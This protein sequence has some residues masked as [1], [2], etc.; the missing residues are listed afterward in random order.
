MGCIYILCSVFGVTGN[1]EVFRYFYTRPSK[2]LSTC[3]YLVTSI[4]DSSVSVTVVVVAASLFNK[5]KPTLFGYAPVCVLFAF[6]CHIMQRVIMYLIG[7]LSV[8]RTFSLVYPL[9]KTIKTK[10]V[11]LILGAYLG[12]ILLYDV[13]L[14]GFLNYS[15]LKLILESLPYLYHFGLVL[16]NKFSQLLC[17]NLLSDIFP[18]HAFFSTHNLSD[19]SVTKAISVISLRKALYSETDAY[20]YMTNDDDHSLHAAINVLDNIL[21]CVQIAIPI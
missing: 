15:K 21:Y 7:T 16:V 12:L 14:T 2:D 3:L 17:S 20:C 8:A 18:I 13:F 6:V 5:R 1:A 4:C 10:T 19:R 9:R 11:F